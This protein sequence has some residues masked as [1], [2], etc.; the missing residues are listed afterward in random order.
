MWG[1]CP[2]CFICLK[3]SRRKIHSFRALEI[4]VGY[5]WGGNSIVFGETTPAK[6]GRV[7][8]HP[9]PSPQKP[10]TPHSLAGGDLALSDCLQG[11]FQP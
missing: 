6:T 4:R 5:M 1:G 3:D 9:P 11:G 7:G 2:K 8:F 10:R